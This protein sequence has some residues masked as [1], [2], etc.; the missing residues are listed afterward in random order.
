[1][2]MKNIYL[3]LLA[4]L[5]VLGANVA[6][7]AQEVVDAPKPR[8]SA[9][10]ISRTMVGD[11]YVK[12]VYGQPLKKGRVI[13]GELEPY[14][15]VWRTGANESTEITFSSDVTFGGTRVSAGTYSLFTIP[16]KDSWTIILNRALGQSGAFQYDET[17]DVVRFEVPVKTSQ[18]MYEAFTV[19]FTEAEG[20]TD[21]HLM[22]DLVH[23][24]A[25]VRL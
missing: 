20:G 18:K 10:A 14:G 1:M 17:K 24:T 6:V 13:F 3:T 9:V 19:S 11:T 7:I 12:V 15:K 25:P 2:Y 16:N 22:W 5:L 8:M 23:I 4:F 21:L